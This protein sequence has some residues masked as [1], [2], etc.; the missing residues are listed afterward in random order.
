MET[1]ISSEPIGQLYQRLQSSEAGLTEAQ[2]KQRLAAL[3]NKKKIS[4]PFQRNLH[5]LARQFA[6]PL[7]ILLIVAVLLSALLGETSDVI[8]I[9]LILLATALTGFLQEANAG[10]AV[11]RLQQLI[12]VKH[13]VLRDA[14]ETE[15]P[16]EDLVPG[17]ILVFNAGDI[18]SADCR[19]ITS[20]ELHVNESALTGESF[21][22]EKYDGEV[23]ADAALGQKHNCLWKGANIISG[24][25]KAL[26]VAIGNDT[27][28]GQL[29]KD[30]D[31][32]EETAFEKGIKSFG[33]FLLRI[34][35]LLS[36]IILV[37]NLFFH[38]PFFES[39]LFSLALAVGMAPEM[40]PAIMTFSMAAGAKKMLKKKVIVKKLS[41][42]FNFGEVNVLC[43]DKTGTITEGTVGLSDVVDIQGKT[44]ERASLYTYLNAAYQ[45]GFSNPIDQAIQ[46][47]KL[48]IGAYSKLDEIPYD[49]IRKRL[50]ILVNEAGRNMMITKGAFDNVLDICSGY[51]D[52]DGNQKTL[53]DSVVSLARQRFSAYAESGLRVLAIACRQ[54]GVHDISQADETGMTFLGFILLQ[55]PI[56]ESAISSIKKLRDLQIDVKVITGDNRFA[57]KHIGDLAGFDTS[58]IITGGELN[59]V[60]P[61]AL[62]QRVKD[63]G[64]FAEIEP[65]QKERIIQA[66]QKGGRT[67]AYMGDGI[68]DVAAIHAADCGISTN[69]AVPVA[70]EA[71][72]FVLLE[73]DL[74]VLADG[75]TEG[76]KS[77]RN[78]M[79]YV[80]ITTGATFGNMFSIALASLLLP[81]LPMLPKQILLNN[82]L[83]DLPF[84]T[85]ASDH[86]D[87]GELK[88]PGTWNLRLIR[89]FM[90]VFGLHSS[91][92]DFITFWFLYYYFALPEK[93]FQTGWFI[94]S[95]ITEILILFIIRTRKP[96]YKSRPGKMLVGV[97]LAAIILTLYLPFSPFADLLGLQIAHANQAIA[98]VLILLL[99]VV[100]GDILKRI[101]FWYSS[102]E[103]RR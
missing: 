14:L 46:Q 76:R 88:A 27:V 11:E 72:D 33:F 49:F 18:I 80:F 64:I 32:E 41:S 26:V 12:A 60:S 93:A 98:L 19:I 103:R 1:F 75:V 96:L 58:R 70:R 44:N 16:T 3:P 39:L 63:T 90:L 8:I 56:K 4:G 13:V 85:I 38:K 30:L 40:L 78:S 2:A 84:L 51:M 50:T 73:K 83:T 87:D 94:E 35:V 77:F 65:H 100:T 69:N 43:T 99:Y 9:L 55:D 91:L 20:N 48:D 92:F 81:F 54:V 7:V 25:A 68:N 21:P 36:L 52:A 42:I 86:V 59:Q 22:V 62:Q 17:D 95:V 45:Q 67:V 24:T 97:A 23:A 61:E 79:K 15:R 34:T 102:P 6:N 47:L 101:F 82:F 10:R 71:A 89:R 53:D 66:L 57:A 37:S 29:S 28:F 5:L 74:E 31:R